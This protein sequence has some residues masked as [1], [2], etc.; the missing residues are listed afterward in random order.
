MKLCQDV[1]LRIKKYIAE[2]YSI[3]LH[4]NLYI[5]DVCLKYTSEYMHESS[6]NH[7]WRMQLGIDQE[8]EK[9]YSSLIPFYIV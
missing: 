9:I 4:Y 3:I 5:L 1:P 7:L 8:D 2:Q 6:N